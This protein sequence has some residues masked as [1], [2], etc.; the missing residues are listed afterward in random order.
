[1]STFDSRNETITAALKEVEK[2]FAKDEAI[3]FH[4]APPSFY[5]NY[6]TTSEIE[7]PIQHNYRK[8]F[9]ESVPYKHIVRPPSSASPSQTPNTSVANLLDGSLPPKLSP[10]P[11]PLNTNSQRDNNIEKDLKYKN[12][13]LTYQTSTNDGLTDY[14]TYTWLK[15][16]RKIT[17]KQC[18]SILNEDENGRK[19]IHPNATSSIVFGEEPVG[20]DMYVTA[21]RES[22][23]FK[24]G[25]SK[26]LNAKTREENARKKKELQSSSEGTREGPFLKSYD[27]VKE[28]DIEY[29]NRRMVNAM[30]LTSRDMRD[31]KEKNLSQKNRAAVDSVGGLLNY[32]NDYR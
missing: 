17:A 7:Q 23:V 30:E 9:K 16:S 24:G 8:V 10:P 32:D 5:N 1:M 15:A 20:R 25:G 28:S 21:S 29:N 19:P 22:M 26:H 6:S 31:N 13:N 4:R 14:T 2:G 18:A 12:T 27:S 3:T 11:K